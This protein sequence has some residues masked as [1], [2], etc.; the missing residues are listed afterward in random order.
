MAMF[1]A[2]GVVDECVSLDQ[3]G[4]GA[5]CIV[6]GTE[7]YIYSNHLLNCRQWKLQVQKLLWKL[8]LHLAV[9]E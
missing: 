6:S 9:L 3:T 4:G 1:R 5:V 8:F 2:Y 7:V